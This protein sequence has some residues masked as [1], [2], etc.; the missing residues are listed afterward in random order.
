MENQRKIYI[1][2]YPPDRKVTKVKKTFRKQA[3]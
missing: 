2:D 1:P 3:L